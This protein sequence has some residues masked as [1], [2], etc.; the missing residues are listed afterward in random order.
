MTVLSD[1]TEPN[2][3]E[4]RFKTLREQVI[5][6]R[7]D[8]PAVQSA[9]SFALL[10]APGAGIRLRSIDLLG[11]SRPEHSDVQEALVHAVENDANPGIRI[12]AIRMLIRLFPINDAIKTTLVR[13]FLQDP[14]EGIRIEAANRLSRLPGG[15]M[16]STFQKDTSVD[17]YVQSLFLRGE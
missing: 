4:I 6:G 12:K 8:D 17:G 7:M 9:L 10:N 14:T 2:R 1:E 13:V 3:V 15:G 11:Q 5:R 16:L